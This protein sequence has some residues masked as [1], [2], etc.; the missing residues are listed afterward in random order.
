M[1]SIC[2]VNCFSVCY[3][4]LYCWCVFDESQRM[5]D[6]FSFRKSIKTWSKFF[7]LYTNNR[8]MFFCFCFGV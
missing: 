8:I 6:K 4:K 3:E 5:Y 1:H 2:K 7:V